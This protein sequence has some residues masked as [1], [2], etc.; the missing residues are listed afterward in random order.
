MDKKIYAKAFER[1]D[2]GLCEYCGS[3]SG[4]ELHHIICGSGKRTQCERLES[5]IFL[6]WNHHH[7]NEGIHGKNGHALELELKLELQLTYFDMGMNEK[8]VRKWMG[9]KLYSEGD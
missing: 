8:E 2:G 6:C 3:N 9:G 1:S 5:V 4:V 7:G